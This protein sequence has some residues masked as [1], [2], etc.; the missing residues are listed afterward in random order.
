MQIS[1]FVRV[2]LAIVMLVSPLCAASET[3]SRTYLT[4]TRYP[5]PA[6]AE[7]G[8]AS[9]VKFNSVL[10]IPKWNRMCV[11]MMREVTYAR[12]DWEVPEPT[13]ECNSDLRDFL[14]KNREIMMR[15]WL[16]NT[17][18]GDHDNWS[19]YPTVF[20]VKLNGRGQL[21]IVTRDW[22][23]GSGGSQTAWSIYTINEV[24]NNRLQ[25]PVSPAYHGTEFQ[26]GG[27]AWYQ[28]S[29][30]GDENAV[31]CARRSF[32]PA[33]DA[34]RLV[35]SSEV[36]HGEGVAETEELPFDHGD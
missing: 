33:R 32:F 13:A 3:T 28:T 23:G 35:F 1:S 4:I 14:W 24:D 27:N 29:C 12:A 7:A 18:N 30:N 31:N 15:L 17:F 26:A 11:S 2:A 20:L 34:V 5:R 10:R 8:A 36:V 22:H 25:L 21:G 6:I 9:E 16:H 19:E